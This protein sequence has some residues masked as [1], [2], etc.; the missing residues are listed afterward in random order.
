VIGGPTLDEHV[1]VGA[2]SALLGPIHVGSHSKIMAGC[3]VA[4]S[5]PP[6]SLV[7]P[8]PV[9]ITSRDD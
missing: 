1:H 5:V 9:V 3:T 2:G 8:A 6:G 7:R 4:Q